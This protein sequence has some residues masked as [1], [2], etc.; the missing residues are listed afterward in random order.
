MISSLKKNDYLSIE[1]FELWVDNIENEVKADPPLIKKLREVTREVWGACGLKPGVKLTKDQFIDLVSE[2]AAA[3]KVA[4]EGGKEP[5]CFKMCDAV[6][7][8]ADTNHVGFL[9]PED[10]EKVMK[11]NNLDA[12]ISKTVFDIINKS[13]DG[14][15]SRQELREFNLSFWFASDDKKLE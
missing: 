5:L 6:Y 9:T 12:A 2:C 3:E 13:H 11:A 4:Y 14:K 15:M 10:Y 1:D 8:V 7:D